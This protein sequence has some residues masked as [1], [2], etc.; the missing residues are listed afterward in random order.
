MAGYTWEPRAGRYRGPDGRFV[1][2]PVVREAVD[3]VI[4]GGADRLADLSQRLVAGRISLAD[5]QRGMAMEIKDLHLA[6]RAAGRG[7]WAQLTAA[8]YGA[9]GGTVRHQYA[10]LARFAAGIAAG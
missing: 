9:V 5:W 1:A 3:A 8:D 10:Y 7:G 6:Q 4:D 2:P